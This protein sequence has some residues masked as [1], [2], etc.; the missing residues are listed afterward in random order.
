MPVPAAPT[1]V[2]RNSAEETLLEGFKDGFGSGTKRI[3]ETWKPLAAFVSL[4]RLGV[5]M[6]TATVR[7]ILTKNFAFEEFIVQTW[8][9]IRVCTLPALAVSMPFGIILA[10]QVGVLAQEVGAVSFTG[11]GNTLA[12]VRQASP[13]ITAL[14]LAGVAGSAICADLGARK[15]REELDALEVMGI[16]IV[17]R[18][19]VPR[20]LATVVVAVLLNG[21]V[22]FFTIMTTLLVSVVLQDLPPGAYLASVTTL[23]TVGDLWLSLAKAAIFGV[24]CTVVAAWKG[25]NTSSGPTGVGDSV[26]SAVV[27]NFILLFAANFLISQV[28]TQIVGGPL[29]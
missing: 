28:H 26:T 5:Q 10:L 19:L 4:L 20:M 11:A 8:Y 23:A 12:V 27:M 17:D 3:R 22:M 29:G 1:R 25:I 18:L 13:M 24:M 6:L 14:M 21:V 9:T 15:I 2:P 7:T 16:S